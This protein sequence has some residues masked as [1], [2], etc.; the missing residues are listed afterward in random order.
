M[1]SIGSD[2]NHVNSTN[3]GGSGGSG[4]VNS[5]GGGGNDGITVPAVG[6]SV[7][8]NSASAT[9]TTSNTPTGAGP[10]SGLPVQASFADQQYSYQYRQQQQQTMQIP[11]YPYYQQQQQQQTQQQQQYQGMGYAGGLSRSPSNQLANQQGGYPYSY[12]PASPPVG[13]PGYLSGSPSGPIGMPAA[14]TSPGGGYALVGSQMMAAGA[15]GQAYA[16]YAAPT[17]GASLAV[18]PGGSPQMAPLSAS[19]PGAGHFMH[20]PISQLQTAK[21]RDEHHAGAI[22]Q[23]IAAISPLSIPGYSTM[24]AAGDVLSPTSIEAV[25][26]RNVYIRNLPEDCTDEVLVHMAMPY[27]EIESSKSIINEETGKCKGY[28][29]VKYRLQHQAECAIEAFNAQGLQSTLAKDSFKSKLKRLQDKSSANVY[30][31]NLS[32]DIDEDALVELIKPYTVVSA[33]ILRDTLTGQHKG[34]GFARMPDRETAML[35]I[36]K[37]KGLRLPN[38]SGPLLPR[39]ADSEGQK[40][41]KKHINGEGGGR[42]D[43]PLVRS[44]TTSPLM[45]SPVLLY[46]PT[47]SPP[48]HAYDATPKGYSLAAS[49]P[50]QQMYAIPGTGYVSSGY[51]SPVGYGSPHMGYVSPGYVSPVQMPASPQPP[52]EQFPEQP[53]VPSVPPV[54]SARAEEHGR[55]KQRSRRDSTGYAQRRR[56]NSSVRPAASQRKGRPDQKQQQQQQQQSSQDGSSGVANLAKNMQKKLAL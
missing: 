37:L 15:H 34:A 16:Y 38:S 23:R 33:R 18:S 35:V 46:S 26:S 54:S 27:G 48:L 39:I 13:S 19:P 22:Q 29:F 41:L 45:W 43:D 47:G 20:I 21:L 24:A 51:A 3:G 36:D 1:P 56:Q 6:S 5:P 12:T 42:F 25:D 31:S 9:I 11:S 50:S 55:D 4:S 2:N 30:I 49:P 53:Q 40:Q 17:G 8:S 28:G 44:E 14:G 32:P 10:G 52:Y 7:T